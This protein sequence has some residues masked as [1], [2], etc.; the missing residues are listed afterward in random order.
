MKFTVSLNATFDVTMSKGKL[1]STKATIQL[2]EV[3]GTPVYAT[4]QV[5]PTGPGQKLIESMILATDETARRER[6]DAKSLAAGKAYVARVADESVDHAREIR[7]ATIEA[8]AVKLASQAADIERTHAR[9]EA[10]AIA[11]TVDADATVGGM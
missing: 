3:N 4:V 1:V 2:G 6:G 8:H 5:A 11:P 7:L 9:T 10:S